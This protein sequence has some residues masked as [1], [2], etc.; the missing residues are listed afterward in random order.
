MC[1]HE[2]VGSGTHGNQKR[3]SDPLNLELQAVASHPAWVPGAEPR[4]LGEQGAFFK[5]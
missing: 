2:L 3:A 4:P 1:G 5:L